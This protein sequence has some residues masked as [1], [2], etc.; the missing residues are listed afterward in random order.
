MPFLICGIHRM[1]PEM[2]RQSI[3]VCNSSK[4]LATGRICSWHKTISST[5]LQH[6]LHRGNQNSYVYAK[7]WMYI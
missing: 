2:W 5:L 3:C 4:Y 6:D 7:C 1:P